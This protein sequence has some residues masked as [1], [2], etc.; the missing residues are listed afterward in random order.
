MIQICLRYYLIASKGGTVALPIPQTVIQLCS[1]ITFSIHPR[2]IVI[3]FLTFEIKFVQ[4]LDGETTKTK[5]VDLDDIYNFV[6][7]N[8]F[9]WIG[10]GS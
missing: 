4:T 9:V 6:V 10:L 7:E 1:L 3:E 8:L 2:K 5:I